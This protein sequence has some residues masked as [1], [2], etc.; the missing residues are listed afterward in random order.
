LARKLQTLQTPNQKSNP[1]QAL[2]SSIFQMLF[3]Y[4]KK[5]RSLSVL[6]ILSYSCQVN[7]QNIT[8]IPIINLGKKRRA[9]IEVNKQ[10][11]GNEEKS[12]TER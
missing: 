5:K 10:K 1:K 2:L 8:S 9:K 4:N 3:Y 6:H 12:S 7:T 11:K